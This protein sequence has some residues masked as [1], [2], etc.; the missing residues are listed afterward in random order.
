MSSLA[1]PLTFKVP[2]SFRGKVNAPDNL[3]A[4]LLWNG[5]AADT[6][7]RYQSPIKSYEYFCTINKIRPWPASEESL[8][9]WIS[10][11]ASGSDSLFLRQ[12]KPDTIQGYLSALRSYH[13]DL[14]LDTD[15]FD[16][17]HLKR[18]LKGAK[19]LFNRPSDSERRPITKEILM[20]ITS[21]L[22]PSPITEVSKT[23]M[24]NF[25]T[26]FKVAFAGFFRLGEI[27]Y[28]AAETRNATVFQA[29]RLT[30]QDVRFFDKGQYATIHLKRSK[31]DH[32]HRGVTV[33]VTASHDSTCPVAALQSLMER[34]P[35]PESAPLFRLSSGAF[36]RDT[37]LRELETR[38]RRAGIPSDGYRGHSFRKG[39]AQEAHNN[40]L[41]QE[42][43]QTLGRWSSDAVQRYFKT[44]RRRVIQ[45]HKQ[46]QTGLA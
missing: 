43:I 10:T 42:E 35:Q 13:V 22:L 6:R 31:S 41:T 9:R 40:G 37:V 26:A 24:L 1:E 28:A 5:L 30:R 34:D 23:N 45:L 20:Q 14:R 33:V 36:T 3:Y 7:R 4:T 16:S 39:A 25:D 46:F 32:D 11:R 38:L 2:A 29:T 8:G 44:N 19:R 17:E 12:A 27:V 21:Q 18:L 15:V